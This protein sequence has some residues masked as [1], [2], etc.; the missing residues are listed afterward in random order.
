MAV[1]DVMQRVANEF[2][3]NPVEGMMS[4]QLK[5]N[6]YDTDKIILNPSEQQRCGRVCGMSDEGVRV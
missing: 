2:N 5:K 4:Q 6:T 3:C 1:T